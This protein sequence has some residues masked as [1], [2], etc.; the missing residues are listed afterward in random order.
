[1]FA[2]VAQQV[3]RLSLSPPATPPHP[4]ASPT[5][6]VDDVDAWHA[7]MVK[8]RAAQPMH[9]G[10]GRLSL[11][12][13][14]LERRLEEVDRFA[15]ATQPAHTATP[16]ALSAHLTAPYPEALFKIRAVFA[17]IANNVAYDY[18]GYLSGHRAD[19]TA[20][21][22]L[23]N[24][25]CVCEGYANL[26]LAL[27]EAA[28]KMPGHEEVVAFKIIGASMGAGAEAGDIVANLDG[29]AWNAVLVHE[30][31]RFI[32]STW[33]SGCIS[34]GKFDRHY[35]PVPHFMVKPTEFIYSHIPK[36][37]SAQQYLSVPITHKEWIELPHCGP[38]F[39][40]NGMRLVRA[41]GIQKHTH[42]ILSYLEVKDDLLEIVVEVDVERHARTGGVVL[43]QITQGKVVP[44]HP[45]NGRTIVTVDHPPHQDSVR[46]M[47]GLA[48]PMMV[49][50]TS[51]TT[52]GKI[53]YVL[54]AYVKHGHF[55]CKVMASMIP[56]KN[57]YYP[58]L[59]FRVKNDGPGTQPPPPTLY[60]GSVKVVEPM[61]GT[62]K[63]GTKVHFKAQG[64]QEGIIMSP[65]KQVLKLVRQGDF[66]VLDVQI[67]ERGDWQV[68]HGIKTGNAT[69][70][71]FGGTFKAS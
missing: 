59:T 9:A 56:G 2:T 5:P 27:C 35:N 62:L 40:P 10:N 8:L 48:Q 30:E 12:L 6:A 51:S 52:P 45:A 47:G 16:A 24:R 53:L 32:E 25:V 55:V 31:Y 15:V 29:H 69:R 19:Q 20:E 70:Y 50:T 44:I 4:P 14:Q 37:D 63:I 28:P 36:H 21:A 66:Q 42:S 67:E 68:G 13:A 18:A 33:A 1:M 57:A 22:V 39:R 54:R 41:R 58:A 71:S 61:T 3:Q 26:F 64:P 23:R 60:A 38:A 65:S 7:A 17:W 46:D 49:H 43:G 11:H 34:N